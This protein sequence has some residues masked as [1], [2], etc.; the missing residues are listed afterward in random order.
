LFGTLESLLW[1]VSSSNFINHTT[2]LLGV[3][4][5]FGNRVLQSFKESGSWT[6][7]PNWAPIRTAVG[8]FP[9]WNSGL[10]EISIWFKVTSK[11]VTSLSWGWGQQQQLL[12][13]S[14][15]WAK[16]WETSWGDCPT[17]VLARDLRFWRLCPT[18]WSSIS[19]VYC[20][21]HGLS[22]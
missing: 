13:L 16:A 17:G 5:N 18:I 2:V 1:E 8:H 3:F 19:A 9:H 15:V 14:R 7:V 11:W 20:L 4:S 12:P 6:L 21:D 22:S 10:Q